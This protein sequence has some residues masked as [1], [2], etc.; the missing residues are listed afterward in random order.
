MQHRRP[1][2][3]LLS[4]LAC[5]LLTACSVFDIPTPA[6]TPTQVPT[7]A[8]ATAPVP[9]PT[10][11]LLKGTVSIWHGWD[12]QKLPGLLKTIAD[13]QAQYPDVV[14]DVQF[15]PLVDLKTGYETAS[16]EGS[17][18]L[19]LLGPASWGPELYDQGWIIDLS[20]TVPEE[21]VESLNLPAVGASR[22]QDAL[23][24]LPVTI[25]GVVLYR[26]R[27]LIPTAATT[28][29]DLVSNAQQAARGEVIGAYLE[30][31]FYYSGGHLTGVGGTLMTP[32]GLPA[33]NNEYGLLW[34]DLL[35]E[36]E[37]AG[38]TEFF[39]DN[40]AQFFRDFRAGYIIESTRLRDN[41]V[42]A[43]GSLNLSIDP[44]PIL[45]K[46]G[47]SGFVEAENVYLSPQAMDPSNRAALEF[48]KVLLSPESQSYIADTGD[49]PAIS[50][51]SAFAPGSQASIRDD[52]IRQAMIAL[53]GGATYPVLPEMAAYTA[54]MDI[55]LQ[56]IFFDGVPAGEALQIA[57][58][59]ISDTISP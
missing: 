32:D 52:L 56:S 3:N 44:W 2:Y 18:P 33:F 7:P 5:L 47:L 39:G 54:P 48:V 1:P 19:I 10:E 57:E 53:E 41:L 16:S 14:F 34:V 22:Y 58:D 23:L 46:G 24:G 51:S 4:I 6:V 25:D 29:D 36:F 37:R 26:N 15:V 20:G 12:E 43:I 50:A 8:P 40:D 45:D 17:E 35:R 55:A 27:G 59:S 9:T 28:L 42:E 21:L 31:S 13:F 38:P 30:R 49:I 11:T